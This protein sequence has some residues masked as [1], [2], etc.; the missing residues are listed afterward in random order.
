MFV[1]V[2]SYSLTVTETSISNHPGYH[3]YRVDLRDVLQ[4]G[5][6]AAVVSSTVFSMPFVHSVCLLNSAFYIEY[7]FALFLS[8][9][10]ESFI[11]ATIM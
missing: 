2:G 3:F 5:K 6:T 8:N 7:V 9:V 10:H 4:A 1:Q 11:F